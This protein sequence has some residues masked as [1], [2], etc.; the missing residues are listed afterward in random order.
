MPA[1]RFSWDAFSDRT[2]EGLA[3]SL[4]FSGAGSAAREWLGQS[5]KC[6]T[7]EFIRETKDA[8]VTYW[9]PE[10]RGA[11]VLVERLVEVGL[12]PETKPRSQSGYVDYIRNTRNCAS[13]RRALLC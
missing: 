5:Y 12:G 2:A 1:Y 4:G 8:L 3:H 11:G 10:Y 7:E 6:P 13:L 9:L